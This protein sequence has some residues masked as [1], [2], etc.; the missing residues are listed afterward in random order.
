MTPDELYSQYASYLDFLSLAE[1]TKYQYLRIVDD[2]LYQSDGNLTRDSVLGYMRKHK[3]KSGT[4]RRWIMYILKSLFENAKVEWPF[5]KR[6]LP[7]LSKPSQPYLRVEDAEKLIAVAKKSSPLN[8]ALVRLDV[9]TGAR[10][11]ELASV[12]LEDYSRPHIR[13]RTAKGGEERVR[14]L[15]P[16]TCDTL[17][18]YLRQRRS[19]SLSLFVSSQGTPLTT[20]T[21]SKRFQALAKSAGFKKGTGW[22]SL[23]RGVTTWLF[24]GGMRERELQEALGW[25]SAV[26]PGKYVQLV[27]GEIEEKVIAIHPFFKRGDEDSGEVRATTPRPRQQAGA[28][29]KRD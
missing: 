21:L 16:E 29:R 22:H 18:A 25:K 11:K 24:E 9:V 26:M 27:A 3:S 12:L 8:Y 14:T 1:E 13:I 17:D 7:K 2:Y 28:K 5:A 20:Q 6:E 23:R 19:K 15:D 10:R 4:Y